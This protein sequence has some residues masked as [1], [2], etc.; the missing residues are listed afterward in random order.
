MY[1]KVVF[2]NSCLVIIHSVQN[3]RSIFLRLSFI[4]LILLF[5][6]LPLNTHSSFFL[7]FY[8][9]WKL[10]NLFDSLIPFYSISTYTL[11]HS[12]H[13]RNPK[14]TWNKAWYN[15]FTYLFREDSYLQSTITLQF[16]FFWLPVSR[17]RIKLL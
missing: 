13:T 5:W 12:I 1:P 10:Y 7:L 2:W 4:L 16:E 6:E 9:Y 17:Q 8:V 11:N 14:K 3:Q 15:N